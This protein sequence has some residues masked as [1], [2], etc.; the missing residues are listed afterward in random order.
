M[1][2]DIGQIISECLNNSLI[3]YYFIKKRE[4]TYDEKEAQEKNFSRMI[5]YC[6]LFKESDGIE[7]YMH[8]NDKKQQIQFLKLRIAD[9]IG[10]Q[11]NEIAD[12]IEEIVRYAFE[13]FIENG[14]VFHAGNSKAIENNMK[15]GLGGSGIS[16]DEKIELMHIAS[17]YSKYGNDNPLGWGV[18]DIKNGKN[19]W[20]YDSNPRYMLYYADSPEW[21]GQFCG[22][23]NCYAWGLVPE[24]NRHGYANRDYNACFLTITKLIEK[25]N[26]SEEDRK[27]ILDFFNKCWDKFGNTEPYLAFVPISSLRNSDYINRMKHYYFPSLNKNTYYFSEDDIFDDILKGGCPSMGDNVCCGISINP[28]VLSC[29]NLSPILPRFKVSEDSKQR[30]MTIQECIKKLNNLDMEFLL[31]A[32]EMLNQFPSKNT[33]RSL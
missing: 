12:K 16:Q 13:N 5:G 20:F 22:G 8:L 32:Q 18:L 30:E 25:N 11:Q 14:Y 26:M 6:I 4:M 31:K 15:Y 21:F 19:G 1:N 28:E 29:V 10:I 27:E 23:N 2:V 7:E 17:I 24:E 3:Q 33:G 9:K